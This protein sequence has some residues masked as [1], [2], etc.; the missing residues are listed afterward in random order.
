MFIGRETELE[1]LAA[2]WRKG[3]ASLVAC[4]GR[5]RIGKSR[6]V[7]EF[8]KRTGGA[9]I[10]L[11]GL[12][13]RPDMTNER[14][15]E[16]FAS[17]LARATHR[18][19][20]TPENWFRAFELL[21]K[22][23]DNRRRTIVLL[24]EISW[25]GGY[26]PDFP[27]YLKTAWDTMFSRHDKLVLV[28]CGSINAWIKKNILDS[29]G[30]VGRFSRDYVLS[31]LTL[32]ESV[33]FWKSAA[34]RLA[35]RE[36]FDVLAI[37]GGIPRYLEE[38]DPGLS[39]DENIR[40]LCFS[41]SG[42]LFKDFNEIFS[43]V[44]GEEAVLK[45]KILALL[46]DGPQTG[47]ELSRW[48]KC[49]NNGHF[50]EHLDALSLAGFISAERGINPATGKRARTG[51]YR[52]RDNYTRFYLKY[53]EPHIV[54]IEDGSY[55]FTSLETL[56]DW[57][58]TMGLQFENLIVNHFREIIPHLHIG[59]SIVVSAAPYRNRRNSRG[60]GC[61]IDL[62]IQTARTA[63]V[64]ETKRQFEIGRTVED[65]VARE[66]KCLHIR[67]GMSVR[68]V[69]VYLGQ[70]DGSVEGDGFFDAIIPAQK[71]LK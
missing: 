16:A 49:I 14:Q 42:T 39:A 58:A 31:E 23:I 34:D 37:T 6:L 63:Y 36:I 43:S 68:P 32:A 4:R 41:P 70:L 33:K 56:P 61:Q 53:I 2:L 60:G 48:L 17:G 59:N 69:L 24:D 11:V 27:G 52:I 8:S 1:D 9:Y 20:A 18:P 57:H 29:T 22:A 64:V 65:Q 62:L 50:A 38:I 67:A 46:A 3:T 13:P 21:D 30:F 44:F 47:E 45:R 25:M 15:L 19:V 12:P 10:E 26:D 40:R 7:V 5:R 71:L 35:P 51:R 66:M 54:E 28:L 55:R